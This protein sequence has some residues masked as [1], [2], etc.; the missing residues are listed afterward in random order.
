MSFVKVGVVGA[1]AARATPPVVS[2]A[3]AVSSTSLTR[4]VKPDMSILPGVPSDEQGIR[5]S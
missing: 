2:T 4:G 5:F 1:S 3:T